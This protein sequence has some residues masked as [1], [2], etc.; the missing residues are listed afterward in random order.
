VQKVQLLLHQ[1]LTAPGQIDENRVHAIA[2]LVNHGASRAV[3]YP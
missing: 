1:Q 2:M 3:L